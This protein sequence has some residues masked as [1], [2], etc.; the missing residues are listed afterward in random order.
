MS[1]VYEHFKGFNKVF[2]IAIFIS[3]VTVAMAAVFPGEFN[4]MST[5]VRD[6]I[7]HDFSWFYLLVV[8]GTVI[9]SLFFIVSPMGQIKLGDPKSQPEYSTVSWLAMLFSAGMGIGLV[10]WG[11]AEP[12]SHY[13]VYPVNAEA[14]TN[15][16][17]EDAFKYTYFHWGIHAWS[18]YGIVALALAYFKYRKKEKSLVSVTL[19]PI[20]YGRVE[21][22]IGNIIDAVTIFVT[23]VGV[24]T[25]LGFGAAQINGGLNQVFGLPISLGN[26]VIIIIIT[27]ILF[28]M[29]ALSGLGKGLKILSNVN[30]ILAISLLAVV[31]AV[32]PTILIMNTFVDSIGSYL[33][34]F[35]RMSFRAAALNADKQEWIQSWTIFYWAWW[36]S[37]SP[38]VGVFIA[39]ISRGRTIREFLTAVLLVPTVL[40]FL[41][42]AAFG[43]ISTNIQR[44]GIDLTLLPVEGILFGAFNLLPWG[45]ILSV[46]AILLI[47][48]F[49]VTSADSATF[50]LGMLSEDGTLNPKPATKLIWG[51][52]LSVISII[53]LASGGL[54]ALQQVLI[55]VAF[56]FSLIMVLMMWSLYKELLHEKKEMGLKI[57]PD[58][59]PA[60]NEPFRSYE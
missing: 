16:A 44:M 10:F 5:A 32:G 33:Q 54:N 40:S 43:T 34:G 19:K 6:S 42:F 55:I 15:A 57:K 27:T 9:L 48:S 12:L 50:V 21:G 46:M 3:A 29:S 47:C 24:A 7:S 26:Q 14:G 1:R 39:R 59:Y 45:S 13:A 52:V 22:I 4:A 31:I 56:P 23:V 18:V 58:V 8:T 37:W 17:L 25:T 38:F 11:V 35:F 20:L 2:W 49:F 30:L 36:I 53:L 28:V 51:I 41:W 60:K